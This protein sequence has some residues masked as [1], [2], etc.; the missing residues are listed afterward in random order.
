[1]HVTNF[2]KQFRIILTF[3]EERAIECYMDI[4]SYMILRTNE[5]IRPLYAYN[6]LYKM[7]AKEN[8]FLNENPNRNKLVTY[9]L[10]EL[11]KRE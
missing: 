5:Y 6:E 3:F 11:A 4:I 7:T 9:I 8:I 1:M 2:D 10:S